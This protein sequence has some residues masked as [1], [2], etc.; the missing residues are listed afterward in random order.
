M[1][2]YQPIAPE[3]GLRVT[4]EEYNA[5]KSILEIAEEEDRSEKAAGTYGAD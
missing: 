3:R 1:D 5:L 2:D 4:T